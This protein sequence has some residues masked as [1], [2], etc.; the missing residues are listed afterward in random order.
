MGLSED[1]GGKMSPDPCLSFSQL[2]GE[3]R[4][5]VMMTKRLSIRLL[6]VFLSF[7]YE[8]LYDLSC[9]SLVAESH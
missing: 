5:R 4:E 7:N 2:P 6:S 9:S 1:E 3:R 8:S